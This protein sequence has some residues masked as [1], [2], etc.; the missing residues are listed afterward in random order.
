MLLDPGVLRRAGATLSEDGRRSRDGRV[1]I[2]PALRAF[3]SEDIS[4][5][6]IGYDTQLPFPPSTGLLD[7]PTAGGLG[8][9]TSPVGGR[10]GVID[11]LCRLPR[12]PARQTTTACAS[13]LDPRAASSWETSRHQRGGRVTAA[14]WVERFLGSI[15]EVVGASIRWRL[16]RPGFGVSRETP[17]PSWTL[18][19]PLGVLRMF[20]VKHAATATGS[21]PSRSPRAGSRVMTPGFSHDI[22][23]TAH[24]RVHPDAAGT[25]RRT[26]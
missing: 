24:A 12:R 25:G 22:T 4:R 9:R 21:H 8:R 26:P 23:T 7:R 17:N 6:F 15:L 13:Q 2:S 18:V 19:I 3:A 14:G 11:A 16:H 20:H 5:W 1:S 10:A